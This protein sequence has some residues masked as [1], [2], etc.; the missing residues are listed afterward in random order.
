[1]IQDRRPFNHNM[2]LCASLL[3]TSFVI[4]CYHANDMSEITYTEAA[5]VI[6]VKSRQIRKILIK[7]SQI[8]PK[9]RYGHRTVRFN[10]EHVLAVKERRRLDAINGSKH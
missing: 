5:A 2:Q 9:I 1:M 3:L 7:Y 10:L 8:C 6:G 4:A